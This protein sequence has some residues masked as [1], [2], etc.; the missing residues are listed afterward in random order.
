MIISLRH[1]AFQAVPA[2][3][4]S[5]GVGAAAATHAASIYRK[6]MPPGS[7]VF[8]AIGGMERSQTTPI[9]GGTAITRGTTEIEAAFAS[10]VMQICHEPPPRASDSATAT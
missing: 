3:T 7:R 8:H 2:S 6:N 4:V 9:I 1:C 5:S 10:D